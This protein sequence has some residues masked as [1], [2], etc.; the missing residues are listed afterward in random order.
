MAN[1]NKLVF[2]EI[3]KRKHHRWKQNNSTLAG[4]SL[5]GIRRVPP[6]KRD[7]INGTLRLYSI[8]NF[9]LPCCSLPILLNSNSFYSPFSR[10]Y[11]CCVPVYLLERRNAGSRRG[12]LPRAFI[13]F[14]VDDYR[15]YVPPECYF[16]RYG[17]EANGGRHPRSLIVRGLVGQ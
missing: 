5:L 6:S 4:C 9:R 1:S 3:R 13:H 12:W 10:W 17:N 11:R 14:R 8:L 2:P 15:D 7:R 16:P